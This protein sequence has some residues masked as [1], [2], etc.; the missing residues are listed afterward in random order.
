MTHCPC[1]KYVWHTDLSCKIYRPNK[2]AEEVNKSS[3]LKTTK[4]HPISTMSK[5][6]R[7]PKITCIICRPDLHNSKTRKIS[8]KEHIIR[9][10]PYI[11]ERT[12]RP[13]I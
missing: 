1:P 13:Q 5:N 11:N 7:W 9:I 6:L 10:E 12:K 8:E 4:Q 3:S 2:T